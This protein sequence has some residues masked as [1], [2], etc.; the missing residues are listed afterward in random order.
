MNEHHRPQRW[1][2]NRRK[3]AIMDRPYGLEY[4]GMVEL[5]SKNRLTV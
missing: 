4:R 5:T 1:C 3:R 2:K